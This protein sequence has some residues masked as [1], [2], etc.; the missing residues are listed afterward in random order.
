MP[1]WGFKKGTTQN[2]LDLNLQLRLEAFS[3]RSTIYILN[4]SAEEGKDSV[5][6]M[7]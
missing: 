7:L 6:T 4:R 5:N 3:K 2:N 1:C